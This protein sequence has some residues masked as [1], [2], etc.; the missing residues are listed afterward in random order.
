MSAEILPFAATTAEPPADAQ[1]VA[2]Y[3]RGMHRLVR[4]VQELSLVRDLEGLQRIVRSAARELTGADGATL[5]LRDGQQCFYADEDA[6]EPLWKGK[7]FPM[8][9]CVSGWVML[10]RQPAVIEDIYMDPR[11][12]H[13]AYR[14]TFVRSLATV[15]IRTES[16][17]GAIGNYWAHRHRPNTHQLALLQALADTTA[18]AL[19]NLQ[20]YADLERRVRDRTAELEAASEEVRR[21]SITD[22]LTH[23]KNRRGFMLM[24][25]Q[26]LK[27][28]RR[29]DVS[30]ALIYLD[31]DGLKAVNDLLGHETGDRMIAD[32]AGLLRRVF[33]ESDII[34]RLGGDE[35][36]VLAVNH[37]DAPEAMVARL[38]EALERFNGQ[39]GKNYRLSTS[40]GCVTVGEQGEQDLE[41][42]LAMADAKMYEDKRSRR[43]NRS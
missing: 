16:P 3:L 40:V 13:D 30:C 11:V 26:E 33:R 18:V 23:L 20:I 19:E 24:A 43:Q 6:I 21:L 42:L 35:F 36:C 31:L 8:E 9:I 7:R 17:I 4:V 15:P 39:M 28:A 5:V 32:F 22:E 1:E 14:P 12:P 34:G 25:E 37:P 27:L 10:N 41:R 38:R 2:R 29:G